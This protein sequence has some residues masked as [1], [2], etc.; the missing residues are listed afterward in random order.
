MVYM[1][2]NSNLPGRRGNIELAAAFGD[3]LEKHLGDELKMLRKFCASL[4][5]I[6]AEAAPVNSVKE[7]LPLSG[8]IGIGAIGAFDPDFYKKAMVKLMR[9][10]NDSRWRMRE[11]VCFGLQRIFSKCKADALHDLEIWVEHGTLL[12]RRAVAAGVADP[13]LLQDGAFALG[14]LQIHKIIFLRFMEEE[15]RP[16]EAFR[17]LRKGLAFSLSVVVS[18]ISEAGFSYMKSLIVED[19][20]DIHWVLKQN[21][22][23][24]RLLGNFPQKVAELQQLLS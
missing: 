21:L 15:N 23:K 12:E 20:P 8:A 16:S 3:L 2:N 10:A 19:D 24:N 18:A 9:L 22:K 4:V 14:A 1:L 17:V 6:S 5:E 13:P 11:A 7:F